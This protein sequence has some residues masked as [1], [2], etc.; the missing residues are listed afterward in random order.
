MSPELQGLTPTRQRYVVTAA[1]PEVNGN[2]SEVARRLGVSKQAAHEI[3]TLPDVEKAVERR[4]ARHL[5]KA[6]GDLRKI[7]SAR[8]KLL[9]KLE[10]TAS[11]ELT[12][13]EVG[14]LVKVAF[15]A[16]RLAVDLGIGTEDTETPNRFAAFLDRALLLATRKGWDACKA[17]EERP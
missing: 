14:G 7:Q 3:L 2:Q 15:E 6:R 12:P 4:K 11:Q 8:R 16:E 17:G 10:D 5:D 9:S 13:I 1:M